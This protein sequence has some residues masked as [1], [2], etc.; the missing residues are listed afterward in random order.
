[1][2]MKMMEKSRSMLSGVGL[3]E[4]FCAEAVG[5]ALLALDQVLGK[6]WLVLE[7]LAHFWTSTPWSKQEHPSRAEIMN[8]TYFEGYVDLVRGPLGFVM[9]LWDVSPWVFPMFRPYCKI[10]KV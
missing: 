3:V 10:C 1:M 2:N 5:I 7:V 8:L 4:E 6:L 9:G